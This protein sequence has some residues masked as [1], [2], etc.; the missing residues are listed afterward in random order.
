MWGWGTGCPFPR[1]GAQQR[2]PVLRQRPSCAFWGC[3]GLSVPASQV[4][5]FSQTSAPGLLAAFSQ[6]CLHVLCWCGFG[7]LGSGEVP[8]GQPELSCSFCCH[9]RA[10][11]LI[12]LA[13][14]GFWG[15]PKIFCFSAR[16]EGK[17]CSE[18]S[19]IQMHLGSENT[20]VISCS[21]MSTELV[22]VCQC[23]NF[24]TNVFGFLYYNY[25]HCFLWSIPR[26]SVDKL[27]NT[28]SSIFTLHTLIFALRSP[29]GFGFKALCC[30][31][32]LLGIDV[33][34][35]QLQRWICVPLWTPIIYS[36]GDIVKSTLIM[37]SL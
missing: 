27:S 29:K 13:S 33:M 18:G 30:A 23:T 2:A 20:E 24:L 34:V 15:R 1:V 3:W 36:D 17:D 37:A 6:S 9:F 31:L 25:E 21:Q 16:M 4:E 7:G 5:C 12:S 14:T 8:G 28:Q 26:H 22:Q 11:L 10:L 32:P 35:K 19:V